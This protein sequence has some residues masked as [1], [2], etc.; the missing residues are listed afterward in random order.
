MP[1]YTISIIQFDD[2]SPDFTTTDTVGNSVVGDT[3][4]V[5]AT[6]E[7]ITI[8]IDDDDP[9]FDDGYID[10]PNNS[11]SGNNQLVAEPLTVNGVDYG[12]SLIHI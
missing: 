10:P 11:T 3:Y 9:D 6:A 4:T 5:S 7:P 2:I 12:L 8:F 1:V